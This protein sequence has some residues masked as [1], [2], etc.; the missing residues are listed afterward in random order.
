MAQSSTGVRL[1]AKRIGCYFKEVTGSKSL[2][3]TTMA[4]VWFN[5]IH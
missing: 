3:V 4:L 1:L 2:A 5:S